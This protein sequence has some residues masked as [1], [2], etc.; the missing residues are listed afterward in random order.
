M[1]WTEENSK[2]PLVGRNDLLQ[3]L[4][5]Y[6]ST[7]W[8]IN[9]PPHLLIYISGIRGIGKTRLL[10]VFREQL[11][12]RPPHKKLFILNSQSYPSPDFSLESLDRRTQ[13][14]S[15][16]QINQWLNQVFEE[17][18]TRLFPESNS[19]HLREYIRLASLGG[20]HDVANLEIRAKALAAG[21]VKFCQE[22]NIFLLIL[23][24]DAPGQMFSWLTRHFY[25]ELLA[26]KDEP[27]K[28]TYP[29]VCNIT[30]GYEQPNMPGGPLMRLVVSHVLE[31]L[32]PEQSLTLLETFHL[33]EQAK[34]QLLEFTAGHPGAL[35]EVSK[36]LTSGQ[37]E[38]NQ[39]FYQEISESISAQLL[40][41]VPADL[42]R[43]CRL[44]APLRRFNADLLF[45]VLSKTL[46]PE[47]P[48]AEA[49]I[50]DYMQLGRRLNE[51]LEFIDSRQAYFMHP[52]IRKILVS[53][54]RY[55]GTDN[56]LYKKINEI[57]LIYYNSWLPKTDYY[58]RFPM[59]VEAFY[60]KLVLISIEN[61]VDKLDR[62]NE[63]VE[64]YLRYLTQKE[65]FGRLAQ[66]LSGDAEIKKEFGPELE[67]MLQ[68]LRKKLP[69][70][71][72]RPA[73]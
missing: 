17:A 69:T 23:H 54:L 60:H 39:S 42:A 7:L 3:Q 43:Y 49:G 44:I 18:T 20:S 63:A 56:Y 50:G 35:M 10:Q 48:Y 58:T 66:H 70:G 15:I 57:A 5:G 34:T 16:E 62:L 21:L 28:T 52:A 33:P 40:S 68:Q 24:D 31:T 59:L 51:Q 30:T 38:F 2:F 8:D 11:E 71:P 72:G 46:N 26:G 13:E 27:S 25:K 6:V 19:E 73:A 61:P 29:R 65:Y 36:R 32:T 12:Q 4:R 37:V 9:T 45:S 64:E 22:K 53:T 1:N 14:S 67:V 55:S 41:K 47:E